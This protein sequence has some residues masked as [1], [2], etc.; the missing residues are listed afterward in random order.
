MGKSKS[1]YS[2]GQE[3]YIGKES[4]H[5]LRF[6]VSGCGSGIVSV[7]MNLLAHYSSSSEEDDV[8]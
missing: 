6:G 4:F 2:R 5:L 1:S 7:S 3:F 8:G